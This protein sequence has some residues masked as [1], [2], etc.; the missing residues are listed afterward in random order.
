MHAQKIIGR[1][2]VAYDNNSYL[3]AQKTL[4]IME[5]ITHCNTYNLNI[6]NKKLC[7]SLMW[8]KSHIFTQ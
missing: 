6:H 2:T 4:S 8:H 3:I 7:D 5:I 1:F